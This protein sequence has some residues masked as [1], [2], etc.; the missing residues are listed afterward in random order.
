MQ[1]LLR[2]AQLQRE[3]VRLLLAHDQFAL[4]RLLLSESGEREQDTEQHKS[5]HSA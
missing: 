3:R 4:N 1:L 5:L 2:L